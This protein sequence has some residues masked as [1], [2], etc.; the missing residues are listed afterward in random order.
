MNYRG[1]SGFGRDFRRKLTGEWGIVDVDDA[2]AAAEYLAEHGE[3]DGERLAI[4]GGSAGGYTALAAL[5]PIGGFIC[6]L[7][8]VQT[9]RKFNA[10]RSPSGE[11]M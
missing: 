11:P 9:L 7:I 1:S 2:V 3:V 10:T 8:L 6:L 4:S 5:A